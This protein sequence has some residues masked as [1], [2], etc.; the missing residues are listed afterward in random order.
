MG[1]Q[2]MIL[3]EGTL[4]D[5]TRFENSV[6]D[7]FGVNTVI[8]D[9]QGQR[10]TKTDMQWAN[11]LCALIKTDLTGA[12]RICNRLLIRLMG[13]CRANKASAIDECAAGMN[14]YVLPIIEN[15][16]IDGFVNICG[17]P[18]LNTDRIY[19]DYIGKTI[20]LKTE[21]IRK[22]LATIK[23]IDPRTVKEMKRYITAYRN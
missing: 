23:P 4:V 15:D 6:Y 13:Q 2:A 7:R 14:K 11:G 17:R 9:R 1:T 3:K 18:L 5:W 22:L 10:R 21:T 16:R 8:L 19:T 20:C 12:S